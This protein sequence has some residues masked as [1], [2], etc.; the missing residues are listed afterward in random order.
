MQ[1]HIDIPFVRTIEVLDTHTEG[2]PTRIIL[3]GAFVPQGL[4]LRESYE[5]LKSNDDQL[6][7]ILNFEPRGNP[8]MCSV[9]LIPSSTSDFEADFG[10]IIME[11]DEYVP[12]CG[13]CIIGAATAVAR[14]GLLGAAK[15]VE[16]V[17][18]ETLAGLVTCEVTIESPASAT[19]VTI[20]NAPSF[21]L[22]RN[23]LVSL[24]DGRE[25][26]VDIAFGG[27]FYAIVDAK[28]VAVE[29]SPDNEGELGR[30]ACLVAE[31]VN[32]QLSIQHPTDVAIDKCYEVLFEDSNR[33]GPG[34]RHVVVSPPGIL[35]RSPCGTGTSARLASLFLRG[36]IV[37]GQEYTFEGVMGTRFHA[38]VSEVG[39][40]RDIPAIVPKIRGR[41]FITG[42]ATLY[43]EPEDPFPNGLRIQSRSLPI[44]SVGNTQR[45]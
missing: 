18:F 45:R 13:H 10:A 5:W 35:D 23:K 3:G 43:L 28:D 29:I 40:V 41:G 21:V 17:R 6:R 1:L 27:D 7:R 22:H 38:T 2:N 44:S 19:W 37:A 42:H 39:L 12:M 15:P 4:T 8:M 20:T 34:F 9:M 36:E 14:L 24:S 25:L 31:A 32:A 26:R 33:V 16:A 30:I 11:Q